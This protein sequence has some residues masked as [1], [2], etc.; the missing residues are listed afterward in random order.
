MK[1]NGF[2][3]IE[4]LAV[5]VI[6]AIIA[7]IATPLVLKYVE[8]SRKESKVD[9]AY[10]FVR[11]LKTEMANYAIEHNGKKYTTDKENI[12][13]LGLDIT[14]KG[15]NPDDGKVCISSLGKIEKGVFQYDNY[16]VSYDGKKGS[17]IDKDT[18]DN[19]SCSG[20][21]GNNTGVAVID[22]ELVTFECY[23][24]E[25]CLG[26]LNVDVEDIKSKVNTPGEYKLIIKNKD[27]KEVL[28][29]DY[30][31]IYY[32]DTDLS[33]YGEQ[34]SNVAKQY[35]IFEEEFTGIVIESEY[36]QK[37]TSGEH[38]VNI[39]PVDREFI[40]NSFKIDAKGTSWL[41][42][43]DIVPDI[44]TN[45][46]IIREDGTEYCN[47][48]VEFSDWGYA[49]FM[50]YGDYDDY[51][52]LPEVYNDIA[53]GKI[54]TVKITQNIGGVDVVTT[55][56]GNNP[57]LQKGMSPSSSNVDVYSIGNNLFMTGA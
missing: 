21:G 19:F 55:I 51:G 22:E 1:K 46:A 25:G 31:L 36:M 15:E 44:P 39:I 23:E 10:S 42:G 4:L 16:Y 6:L 33:I 40:R 8:K 3:L 20:N 43:F 49:V 11:N 50:S 45:V 26:L 29:S 37:L 17:I 14:V 47:E 56:A 27:T 52:K 54:V 38:I 34:T 5:I 28:V 9:S 57:I 32:D 7:L 30:L 53:N 2:T 13:E 18:Y 24:N 48:T 35:I 12:K 41:M